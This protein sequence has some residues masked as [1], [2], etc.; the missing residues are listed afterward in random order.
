ME[1]SCVEK[2]FKEQVKSQYPDRHVIIARCAHLTEPQP[3]HQQQG[4]G[5]C[6][7]RVLCQRGCPYGGYFSSNAST[8][9]WAAKTGNLTLRPQAVVHSIMYDDQKDKATGVRLLMP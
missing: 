5:K 1:L 9:P 4:R 2:Y 7:H 3:I 8:L 6:Q